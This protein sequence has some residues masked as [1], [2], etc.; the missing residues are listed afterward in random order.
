LPLIEGQASPDRSKFEAVVANR[1][2]PQKPRLMRW[3]AF[4]FGTPALIFL[5]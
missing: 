3:T 5:L 2:S 4:F 1:D